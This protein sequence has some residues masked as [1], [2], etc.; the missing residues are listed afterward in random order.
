MNTIS[1]DTWQFI[2]IAV[3]IVASILGG[4]NYLLKK[5]FKEGKNSQRFDDVESKVNEYSKK[6]TTCDTRFSVIEQTK[7]DSVYMEKR[8]NETLF[9]IKNEI[10]MGIKNLTLPTKQLTT[11]PYAVS[12]SPL[13]LTEKGIEKVKYL[14]INNMIDKKWNDISYL[15]SNNI[16][17]KNPYDIQQFCLE[18]CLLFPEKFLEVDDLDKLKLDAYNEGINIDPYMRI[19]AILSFE[20]FKQ[21]NSDHTE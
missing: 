2:G 1:I 3:A 14:G 10:L 20:K 11:D 17:S 6:Q 16:K 9:T 19:I 4:V 18:Q 15:I 5:S 8:F 12:H 7:A 21:D 13:A